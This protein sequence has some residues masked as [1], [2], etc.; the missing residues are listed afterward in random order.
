MS[1][2][3]TVDPERM[4][5][6]GMPETPERA[7][8]VRRFKAQFTEG[9]GRTVDV[10]VV[11]FGERITHNDGLGGVPRGVQYQEE[12][13]PGVFRHQLKAADKVVGNYE[14]LQGPAGLVAR[15]T[16]LREEADGY[17]A[18]FRML[19]GSDSDKTLELIREGVL[20]GVS[21]EARPVKNIRTA[22]GVIQRA[23][24]DLQAVAFTRFAA[25]AG[26]RVL[27]VR[28][29]PETTFDEEMLPV[30]IDPELVERCRRLGIA[31]PER[32][33]A[34]P[35]TGTSADADIPGDGTRHDGEPSTEVEEAP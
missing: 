2:T 34:H 14:H 3:Y 21:V 25:F 28:E 23:K 35:A 8:L 13:L 26:A 16:E 22:S 17:H 7:F 10:R 27:A 18:T 33:K 5:H 19:S 9:D 12:W 11:P 24:A 20:D 32:L 30:G 4:D 15:A 31:L 1:T 6:T 29:K